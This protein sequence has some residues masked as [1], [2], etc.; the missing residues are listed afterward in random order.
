VSGRA[1]FP[2]GWFVAA[3]VV[4]LAGIG[5]AASLILG[6]VSA[7]EAPVRLLAPGTTSVEIGRPGRYIVWHEHSTV[8]DRRTFELPEKLPHGVQLEVKAPDG[9]A[10]RSEPASMSV[11]WGSVKRA[12]IV[13]FEASTPG[14]YTVSAQGDAPPFVLAVGADFTWPL[15]RAIGGAIAAAVLGLGAALA[16]ALYGFVQRAPASQ[17]AGPRV[18]DGPEAERRLRNLTAIV[19]ALQAVSLVLGLTLIAGVIIN[20][21]KQPE[22]AGTWLES[23]FDW[24]IRTFWWTLLWLVLGLASL[25]VFV[26]FPVLLGAAIWLVYRVA[27]GWIALSDGK[28]IGLR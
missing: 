4:A 7:Y 6:F 23:H 1:S 22:V 26:G 27:R 28:P 9:G 11:T 20:V 18:A 5:V 17:G 15:L 3:G 10:L 12:A 25:V 16:L 2:A 13:S 8:F 14:R 19:Y 21:L 24:Q